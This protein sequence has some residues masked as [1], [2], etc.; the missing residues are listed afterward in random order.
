MLDRPNNS[1]NK[2]RLAALTADAEFEQLVRATF[3]NNAQIE[4]SVVKGTLIDEGGKL[5]A[6]DATVVIVDLDAQRQDELVAL[7]RLANR[8]GGAPPLVVVTQALPIFW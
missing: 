7:H 8:L 2:T 1:A 5:D 6:R 3:G 4:L